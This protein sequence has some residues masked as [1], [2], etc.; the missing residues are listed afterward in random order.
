MRFLTVMESGKV[1]DSGIWDID[2]SE[3]GKDS[4]GTLHKRIY[5]GAVSFFVISTSFRSISQL[6]IF[7]L[8]LLCRALGAL[9]IN[10]LLR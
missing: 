6:I 2:S 1:Y 5:N 7:Y 3:I 4:C 10:E 8:L 9:A